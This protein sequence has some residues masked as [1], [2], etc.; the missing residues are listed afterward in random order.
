MSVGESPGENRDALIW[1]HPRLCSQWSPTSPEPSRTRSE[2]PARR[3]DTTL[4]SP[5]TWMEGVT[6]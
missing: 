2:E 4:P 5:I 6:M 3:Y 1:I